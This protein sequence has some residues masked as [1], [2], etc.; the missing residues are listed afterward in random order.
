MSRPEPLFVRHALRLAITIFL[1]A[2]FARLF[3]FDFGAWIPISVLIIQGTTVGGM[4]RKSILRFWGIALGVLFGTLLADLIRNFHAQEV[5]LVVALFIT[6]YMRAFVQVSY[7]VLIIPVVITIVFIQTVYIG[8]IDLMRVL[9][10]RFFATVMGL[11]FTLITSALILPSGLTEQVA[12]ARRAISKAA[13]G[14]LDAIIALALGDQ[15][16]PTQSTKR[17]LERT[18]VGYRLLFPD[19]RQEAVRSAHYRDFWRQMENGLQLLFGLHYTVRTPLPLSFKNEI[20]T[21]AR[22]LLREL[23]AILAATAFSR[24]EIFE[25][26]EAIDRAVAADSEEQTPGFFALELRY[27]ALALLELEAL[28]RKQ[29]TS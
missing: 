5:A 4:V 7:G 28:N 15:K 24:E 16:S 29:P 21:P 22:R 25:S 2:L 17:K 14:Y 27:F 6:Y 9:Q 18:L 3:D 8:H 1:A 11:A 23:Q 12:V 26:I 13:S 19:T 10:G 20:N